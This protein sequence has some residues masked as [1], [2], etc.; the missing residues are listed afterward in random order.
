VHP[1]TIQNREQDLG[2]ADRAPMAV[3]PDMRDQIARVR[4]LE[5]PERVPCRDCWHRGR[6]AVLAIMER[7]QEGPADRDT[8]LAG[9]RAVAPGN[10]R[11][12][13]D[14][15]NSGRDAALAVIEGA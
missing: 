3:A 7:Q 9:A 14:A 6:R 10:E 1:E 2:L 15:F 12:W 13:L 11:H 8:L 5:P 4:A